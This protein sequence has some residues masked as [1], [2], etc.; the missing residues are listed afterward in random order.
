MSP[1]DPWFKDLLTGSLTRIES[2]VDNLNKD[3]ENLKHSVR[4]AEEK[5]NTALERQEQIKN[6]IDHVCSDQQD[7]EVQ[8]SALRH[9]VD[10]HAEEAAPLLRMGPRALDHITQWVDE[11]IAKKILSKSLR[12]FFGLAIAFSS[13]I[14]VIYAGWMWLKNHF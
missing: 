3:L 9:D 7:L 6:S 12:G 8:V 5:A 2:K 11:D 1:Q 13:F 10:A 4:Q 14:A